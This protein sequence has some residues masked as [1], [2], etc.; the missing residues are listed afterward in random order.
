MHDTA[1]DEKPKEKQKKLKP[2]N[3]K[4]KYHSVFRVIKTFYN[5]NLEKYNIKDTYLGMKLMR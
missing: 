2:T 1:S 4:K 3:V 5:I